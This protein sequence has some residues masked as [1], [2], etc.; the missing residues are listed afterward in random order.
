[1]ERR[2]S[3]RKNNLQKD[4]VR[5]EEIVKKHKRDGTMD[6]L[7]DE[8]EMKVIMRLKKKTKLFDFMDKKIESNDESIE[9]TS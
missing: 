1:M 8:E 3:R 5:F 9:Q 4:L 7:L 6:Q 2:S